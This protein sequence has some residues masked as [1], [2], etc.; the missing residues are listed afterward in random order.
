MDTWTTG[1]NCL[2]MDRDMDNWTYFNSESY[3]SIFTSDIFRR[4]E[5]TLT[6][7]KKLWCYGAYMLIV[8]PRV[9]CIS[10]HI[11][12]FTIHSSVSEHIAT[13]H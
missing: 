10:Q 8:V 6:I 1:N 12:V 7:C 2:F 13:Y 9:F 5:K 3:I 11:L 4:C